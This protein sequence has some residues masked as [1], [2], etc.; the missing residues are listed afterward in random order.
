MASAS[1]REINRADATFAESLRLLT[2]PIG[3]R[4]EQVDRLVE[5]AHAGYDVHI[6]RTLSQ[7]VRHIWNS[8][9]AR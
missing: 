9:I 3:D 6:A 1:P 2:R 7:I 8:P 5:D 4:T